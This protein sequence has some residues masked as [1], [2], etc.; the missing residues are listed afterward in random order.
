MKKEIIFETLVVGVLKVIFIVIT[1]P[2]IVV[3]GILEALVNVW[4][5]KRYPFQEETKCK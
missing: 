5:L 4:K 2:W 1:S 3:G